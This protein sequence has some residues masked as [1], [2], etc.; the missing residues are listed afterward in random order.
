MLKPKCAGPDQRIM[1]PVTENIAGRL[2]RLPLSPSS[3]TLMST[4]RARPL[5]R[6]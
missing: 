5:R 1:L 4:A 6:P 3:T 2:V